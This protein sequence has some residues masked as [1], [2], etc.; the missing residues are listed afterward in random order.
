MK[1]DL[2]TVKKMAHLARLQLTDKEIE[3]MAG[4]MSQI[5]TWMEKLNEVDVTG[6]EPL[7][8]MSAELNVLREDRVENQFTPE[9]TFANAPDPHPPFFRV[10]KVVDQPS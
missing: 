4:S 3:E 9:Q 1:T 2:E 8:H 5:L 7:V 10:P 6:V